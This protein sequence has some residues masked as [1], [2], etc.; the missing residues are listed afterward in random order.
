MEQL[1]V[2][3]PVVGEVITEDEDGIDWLTV[4]CEILVPEAQ[5]LKFIPL[6]HLAE[7]AREKTPTAI[8]AIRLTYERRKDAK[9]QEQTGKCRGSRCA[10][11]HVSDQEGELDSKD[12]SDDNCEMLEDD[13]KPWPKGFVRMSMGDG[14]F[15]Y[16]S[17][18]AF[19]GVEFQAAEAED[20][21]AVSGRAARGLGQGRAANGSRDGSGQMTK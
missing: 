15:A 11:S 16:T 17:R 7:A 10:G 20:E 13:G 19:K 18:A 21:S 14:T 6:P 1:H 4:P 2:E 8:Q 5:K 12:Y 3:Q 9:K